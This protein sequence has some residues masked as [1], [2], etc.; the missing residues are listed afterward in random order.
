MKMEEWSAV[1]WS[2]VYKVKHLRLFA[3][4]ISFL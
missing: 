3:L 1:E 2:G 4:D